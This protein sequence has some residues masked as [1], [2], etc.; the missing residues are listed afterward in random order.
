MQPMS[1]SG[2]LVTEADRNA[3][4]CLLRHELR[5]TVLWTGRLV[6]LCCVCVTRCF[7]LKAASE[8]WRSLPGALST[9]GFLSVA[10]GCATSSCWL[11][12]LFEASLWLVRER[13]SVPC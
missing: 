9:A 5:P 4:S 12:S 11:A 2:V 6:R 1:E 3:T 10:G 8:R 7:G 13:Y